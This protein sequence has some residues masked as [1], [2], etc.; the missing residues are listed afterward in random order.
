MVGN[1]QVFLLNCSNYDVDHFWSD[2]KSLL[3]NAL[4]STSSEKSWISDVLSVKDM[5]S[6]L[7]FEKILEKQGTALRNAGVGLKGTRFTIF[8]KNRFSLLFR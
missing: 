8:K 2:V 6:L 3:M 7:A 4:A 5:S 1:E